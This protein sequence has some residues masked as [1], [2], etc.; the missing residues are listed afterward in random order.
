M[1]SILDYKLGLRKNQL[2]IIEINNKSKQ[3]VRMRVEKLEKLT[4]DL[5]KNYNNLLNE[6]QELMNA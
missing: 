1:I 3:N 5:V 4:Q 2:T 6:V